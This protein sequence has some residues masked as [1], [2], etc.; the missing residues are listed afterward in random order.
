MLR[1]RQDFLDI[2]EERQSTPPEELYPLPRLLDCPPERLAGISPTRERV[3][4]LLEVLDRAGVIPFSDRPPGVAKRDIGLV[5]VESL[6][7]QTGVQDLGIG[8]AGRRLAV[9]IADDV[10]LLPE[11]RGHRARGLNAAFLNHVSRDLDVGLEAVREDSLAAQVRHLGLCRVEGF[12]R[13]EVQVLEERGLRVDLARHFRGAFRVAEGE[14]SRRLV[15]RLFQLGGRAFGEPF[16]IGGS[17]SL[18]PRL[19]R[20][21]AAE[22]AVRGPL[23]AVLESSAFFFWPLCPDSRPRGSSAERAGGP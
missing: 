20:G 12:R 1:A 16:G 7:L 19:Q 21:L 2:R 4:R 23:A 5:R 15:Q 17:P 11:A 3:E 10:D 22:R 14:L 9:R 18:S 8:D 6:A 13:I